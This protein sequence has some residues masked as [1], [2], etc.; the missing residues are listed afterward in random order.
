MKLRL[1]DSYHNLI[2]YAGTVLVL[3]SLAMF[4]FLYVLSSISSIEKAYEGLVIFMVIPVFIILGLLLI[5][6]GM[7]IK[8]RRKRRA[9]KKGI[10]LGVLDLNK[11]QNRNAAAIFLSGTLIFLFLSALGSYK[12]YHFTDSVLFCGTLCHKVMNPEYTAYQT[13]PHAR[14]SCAEC[15]VGPGA[16]WY[17]KSKLSGLYQV[18]ATIANIYPRPIPAPIKS[19][20]PARETCEQCHWPQKVY[21]K[22][23]RLEI[24]YL[25]DKNNTRWDI[26][27]L[28]NTGEG[29]PAFGFEAGIHWHINRDIQIEYISTDEERLKIAR[30][31]LTKKNTNERIVYNTTEEKISEEDLGKYPVRIMDCIDCHNRPSHIYRSPTKFINIAIAS[32]KIDS[33]LPFIK[34]VAVQACLDDF[35]SMTEALDNIEQNVRKY[36]SDNYPD[37]FKEHS[38]RI[39]T[40]IAGIQEAFSQNIFPI[41]NVR[42]E[43]Y[44]DHIGHMNTSGCFR[45]HDDQH[46]SENGGA[47]TK[48]CSLCHIIY[49]QG[50]YGSMN[51]AASDNSLEFRHP[52]DIGEAWKEVKCVECHSTP[53]L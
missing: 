25:P 5:P 42:W 34:K 4:I 45:C 2:S 53:P 47:I 17:V 19:L 6:T 43:A 15:H 3:V 1:P 30:V 39:E 52:E 8:T 14:V 10:S 9:T 49:G 16:S 36:Y 33:S 12:A 44:P 7:F 26:E 31:I 32:G 18:Y 13:S 50:P 35:Q 23:Q 22:Q 29:N 24:H 11:P 51:Y 38:D 46:L 28:L 48:D 40:S 41:M 37:I 27:L 21:G 20:R